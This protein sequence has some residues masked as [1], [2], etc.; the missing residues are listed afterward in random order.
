MAFLIL[1][2]ERSLHLSPGI[3]SHRISILVTVVQ[4]DMHSQLRGADLVH[5]LLITSILCLQLYVKFISAYPFILIN[6]LPLSRLGTPSNE[7]LQELFDNWPQVLWD[8]AGG[9]CTTPRKK[10]EFGCMAV[11]HSE[12]AVENTQS[13]SYPKEIDEYVKLR[14]HVRRN[15]K[16]YVAPQTIGLPD[17][18]VVVGVGNSLLEAINLCKKRAAMIKGFGIEV[19]LGSIDKALDTIRE[20]EKGKYGF[21]KKKMALQKIGHRH[22]VG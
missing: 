21:Q 15:G 6:S 16:D 19:S 4:K 9:V 11:I 12:F 14:F 2:K 18:G 7:L 20:G 8:G 22:G 13:I 3:Y 5:S 17:L 10:F 1:T